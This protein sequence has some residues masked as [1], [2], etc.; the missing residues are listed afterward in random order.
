MMIRIRHRLFSAAAAVLL[1]P[2]TGPI[3]LPEAVVE[4]PAP[5]PPAATAENPTEVGW[6]LL[7]TLNYRTGEKGEEL[8]ALDGKLV[9]VPGF[10]VPLE[11]W[12]SSASEV[13]LVP[14]V[15]ACIHTPPPPPNQLV[16]IEM[17][18][19]KRATL[20]GWNPVWVE[21][22]LT[23]EMTESMYGYVGFTITGHNVYPYEY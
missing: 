5:E 23:I 21:G 17:E 1:V 11:D 8:A 7:A 6:R 4:R 22:I 2:V 13:L 12:A 9:K 14:Y 10:T 15:G 3:G 19:G 18:G 20:D 16:Y